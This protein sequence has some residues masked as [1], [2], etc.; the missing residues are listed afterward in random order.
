MFVL[1]V[2]FS[3][4]IV[5]PVAEIYDKQKEFIT[6]AGHEIKTPLAI[7][8]ADA[9]VIEM[10]NGESEWTEDIKNQTRRLSS[11]T[12]DLIFLAKM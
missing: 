5:R 4:R 11:L 10:E 7:I 3:R 9:D 8:N 6:N 1:V 12:N 2:I